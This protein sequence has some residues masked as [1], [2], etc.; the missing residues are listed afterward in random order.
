MLNLEFLTDVCSRQISVKPVQLFHMCLSP[1]SSIHEIEC[2]LLM[3][4][5]IALLVH[6]GQLHVID[7]D[8]VAKHGA[9]RA[10]QVIVTM[11]DISWQI[12]RVS[13]GDLEARYM[14]LALGGPFG[15]DESARVV[16]QGAVEMRELVN[17]DSRAS[18][19]LLGCD[20]VL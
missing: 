2:E 12:Q 6:T 3:P 9:P 1:P 18:E 15:D 7:L 11:D 4:L 19:H 5:I 8:L 13:R 17:L 16:L 20:V 10:L 14:Q